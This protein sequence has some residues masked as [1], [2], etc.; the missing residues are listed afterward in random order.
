MLTD[1]ECDYINPIDLANNLNTY[2]VPEM[3][4]HAFIFILFLLSF[5][6]VTVLIN[7]PLFAW[8]V[9]KIVKSNY[10]YD[11]TEVFR[12]LEK[13]KRENFVKVGFY[14]LCFF[15]YLY[16]MIMSLIA[17]SASDPLTTSAQF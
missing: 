6:W 11:A 5:E 8:N 7:L 3:A 2:V 14:L 1:L 17:D 9:N 16:S 10:R 4:T 12:T 13:H 15:Y